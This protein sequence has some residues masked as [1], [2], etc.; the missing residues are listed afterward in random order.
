MHE[1][2]PWILR[3]QI[4]TTIHIAECFHEHIVGEHVDCHWASLE[5]SA[6]VQNTEGT[7][8]VNL[9]LDQTLPGDLQN[10]RL[11]QDPQM[12]NQSESMRGGCDAMMTGRGQ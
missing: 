5:G 6:S 3:I 2:M 1:C 11:S 12:R 7:A 4:I 9:V 10:D 8:Y